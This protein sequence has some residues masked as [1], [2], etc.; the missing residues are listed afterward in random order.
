M[1]RIVHAIHLL[2]ISNE[3]LDGS[4]NTLFLDTLD[5]QG[6]GNTLENGIGTEAFPVAATEWLAT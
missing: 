4:N 6:T 3:M 5:G 2:L 1:K